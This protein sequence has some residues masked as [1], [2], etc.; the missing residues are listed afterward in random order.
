MAG[1]LV[2]GPAGGGKSQE[3][4]A[5]MDSADAPVVLVDFQRIYAAISGDERDP[6][7]GRYPSRTAALLPIAEYLRRVAI[8]DAVRQELPLVVTNASGDPVRR[9]S[10]IAQ[11]ATGEMPA[12]FEAVQIAEQSATREMREVLREKYGNAIQVDEVVLDPGEGVVI[13]RLSDP[14]GLLSSDC[15]DAKDR[16]YRKTG[17]RPGSMFRPAGPLGPSAALQA[18]NRRKF[19]ALKAAARSRR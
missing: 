10:L 3:V 6:K 12:E 13:R 15:E 16:W 19:E 4:A 17:N 18:E 11:M 8:T 7:T 14:L 5:F 9:A 1:L 2:S